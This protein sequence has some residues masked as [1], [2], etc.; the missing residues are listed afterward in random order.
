MSHGGPGYTSIILD[1][2][3]QAVYDGVQCKQHEEKQEE[4][5]PNLFHCPHRLWEYL[6]SLAWRCRARL[7]PLR[8]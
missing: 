5:W 2:R 6:G 3:N 1:L 7:S 4:I 8:G